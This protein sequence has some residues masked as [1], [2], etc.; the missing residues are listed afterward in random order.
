MSA[1]LVYSTCVQ[2]LI[3]AEKINVDVKTATIDKQKIRVEFLLTELRR[4]QVPHMVNGG[5]YEGAWLP[6]VPVDSKITPGAAP[7]AYR[8]RWTCCDCTCRS[9]V[10][11]LLVLL[12]LCVLPVVICVTVCVVFCVCTCR[13]S[14]YCKPYCGCKTIT[15]Q[16]C[17]DPPTAPR[18]HSPVR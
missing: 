10:L 18:L 12:C 14:Y 17:D 8:E 4:K 13:S 1:S 15:Q 7:T 9:V 3:A 2:R 6:F 5:R 11:C 16:Y